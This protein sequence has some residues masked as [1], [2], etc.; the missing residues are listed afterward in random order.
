MWGDPKYDFF[1]VG[2]G[3]TGPL[4]A[5]GEARAIQLLPRG[6]SR[7]QGYFYLERGGEKELFVPTAMLWRKLTID[8]WTEAVLGE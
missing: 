2:P 8:P 5:V 7:V 1:I 6:V 3:H 4:F